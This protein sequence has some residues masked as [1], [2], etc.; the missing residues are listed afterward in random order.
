MYLY[1]LSKWVEYQAFGKF[2][3]PVSQRVQMNYIFSDNI[4]KLCLSCNGKKA[5]TTAILSKNSRN[6]HPPHRFL[7]CS[8]LSLCLYCFS[9]LLL[10]NMNKVPEKLYLGQ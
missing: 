10:L 4:H 5:K 6:K 1:K 2:F 9:F 7:W 3:R 8:L